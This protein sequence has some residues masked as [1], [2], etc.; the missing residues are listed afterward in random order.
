MKV[1]HIVL[2]SEFGSGARLIGQQLA[3]DL[4]I[5]FYGEEILLNMVAEQLNI[6]KNI[7][8]LFDDSFIENKRFQQ[9]SVTE[10]Q[11]IESYTSTIKSLAGEGPCIF[12]ER[13]SDFILKESVPFLN[14][15]VYTSNMEKKRERATRVGGVDKSMTESFVLQQALQRKHFYQRYTKIQRGVINE[16]DLCINSDTLTDDPL[17]MSKCVNILKSVMS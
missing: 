1:Q 14:V 4:N 10:Q 12:M 2:T 5:P 11:I 9:E 7:L 8:K 3:G 17:D 16:Y 15:Y 13:G 6:D